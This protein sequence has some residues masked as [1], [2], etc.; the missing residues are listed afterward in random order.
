[1]TAV[2]GPVLGRVAGAAE[3]DA[4]P[5]LFARVGVGQAAAG[6]GGAADAGVGTGDD[7]APRRGGFGGERRREPHGHLLSFPV[8]YHLHP[9][10]NATAAGYPVPMRPAVL[11]IGSNSAQL[12][13]V[14]VSAG[15]PPLPAHAVKEP[16][17]LA[18]ELTSDADRRCRG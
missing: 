8:G 10:L 2:G 7:G 4:G 3:V 15:A 17:L 9:G 6:E 12:Q 13:V 16:P 14:D 18:E 11:D 1:V 5:V